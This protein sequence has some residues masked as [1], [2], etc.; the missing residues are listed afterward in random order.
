MRPLLVVADQ[1]GKVVFTTVNLLDLRPQFA[2][3][4][5]R[6]RR[7]GQDR[8]VGADRCLGLAL[9]VVHLGQTHQRLHPVHAVRLGQVDQF[10]KGLACRIEVLL[11]QLRRS[12][13]LQ[14]E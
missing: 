11:I 10:L 13:L 1:S 3:Q 5:A 9:A 8:L 6:F 7:L 4:P 2:I 14:R 12:R